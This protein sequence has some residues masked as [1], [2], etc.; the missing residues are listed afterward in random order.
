C[1][2]LEGCTCPKCYA[3]LKVQDTRKRIYKETQY[4]S[5]ITTC[6]GY[7]VIRVAQVRCESRKGEPM[8][9]Y[10]HEVVQRWIS[11]DGKVTD[12]ALLRGFTFYYC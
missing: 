2:T 4:F 3:K 11:P 7:Q 10:C 12:M 1:D 8:H 5:V 6:K 9:F